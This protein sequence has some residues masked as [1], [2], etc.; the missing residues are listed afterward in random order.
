MSEESIGVNKDNLYY[1]LEDLVSHG[2]NVFKG[3]LYNLVEASM[4]DKIQAEALKGLI[5]GFANDT[6]RNTVTDMRWYARNGGLIPEGD[7]SSVVG[8]AF[9]LESPEQSIR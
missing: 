7:G 3:K 9:P 8:L 1:S 4:P 2:F 5:K 6:Y